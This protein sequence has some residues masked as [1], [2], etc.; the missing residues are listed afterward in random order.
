MGQTTNAQA[1]IG[2]V[3]KAPRGYVTHACPSSLSLG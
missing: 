2:C 1:K 3:V